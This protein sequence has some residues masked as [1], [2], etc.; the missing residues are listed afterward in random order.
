M[1]DVL[2]LYLMYT[3]HARHFIEMI[4]A[5]TLTD[6]IKTISSYLHNFRL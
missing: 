2:H 4:I 6:F 5:T 1:F 3:Y